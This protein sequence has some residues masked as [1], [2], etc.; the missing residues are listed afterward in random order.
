MNGE[1][2]TASLYS[3]YLK[4]IQRL[5]EKD[6]IIQ[7]S[8]QLILSIFTVA[9]FMF[10]AIRPTLSTIVTLTKKI[11]DQKTANQKLDIKITQLNRAQEFLSLQGESL[12]QLSSV[13]VPT[14]PEV[15][16]LAQAIEL[17][18]NLNNVYLTNLS[19]QATPLVGGKVSLTEEKQKAATK[20]EQ[21]VLLNFAVG[22]EQAKIVNFLKAIEKLDRGIAITNI[23]FAKPQSSSKINL[24]LVASIKATA[25]YLPQPQ[26]S[27]AGGQAP[28]K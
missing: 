7:V 27:Q 16:R 18:A 3:G 19:F 9:F 8:L 13:A 25:Y 6:P 23:S 15:K 11:E 4:N 17:T 5:Y 10:L 1:S 26:A 20:G 14:T 12:S 21:F 28:I 2:N 22:G 24:P